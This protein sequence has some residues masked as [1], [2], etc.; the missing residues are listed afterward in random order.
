[1]PGTLFVI[2]E[3]FGFLVVGSP[4][5]CGPW[6]PCGEGPWVPLLRRTHGKN[7]ERNRMPGT[8]FVTPKNS[9]HFCNFSIMPKCS[10]AQGYF[11]AI[12]HHAKI[13]SGILKNSS[14][15]PLCQSGVW[16]TKIVKFSAQK[17]S[18]KICEKTSQK[19]SYLRKKSY[20]CSKKNKHQLNQ[21]HHE[22][23]QHHPLHR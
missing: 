8:L 10:P 13:L 15:F 21:K 14:Y 18:E 20:I 5:R 2:A 4:P 6:T 1:M 16:H 9:D 19:F 12:F 3:N 22:T 7:F 23:D 17:K 11:S